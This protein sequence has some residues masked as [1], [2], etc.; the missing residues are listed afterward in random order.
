M[1]MLDAT[2]SEGALHRPA[3]LFIGGEPEAEPHYRVFATVPDGQLD[4][5]RRNSMVAAVTEAVLDAEDGARPR[6]P[7]RVWVLATELP[8]GWWGASGR[9]VRLEDILTFAYG[10]AETGRRHAQERLDG[11]RQAAAV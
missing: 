6:E 7:G 4:D 1:P 9:I 8:D 11:S 10:D 2:I 5:E 3:A